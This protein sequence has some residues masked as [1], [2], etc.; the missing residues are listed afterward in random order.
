[1]LNCRAIFKTNEEPTDATIQ[2]STYRYL[3]I[4]SYTMY[5]AYH[6]YRKYSVRV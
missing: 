5:L 2:Y 4:R 6:T 3:F 1:M